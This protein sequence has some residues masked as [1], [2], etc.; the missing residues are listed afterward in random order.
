MA[1]DSMM[2][3]LKTKSRTRLA[4]TPFFQFLLSTV[5]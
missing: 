1:K 5:V 4:A 3:V 2:K